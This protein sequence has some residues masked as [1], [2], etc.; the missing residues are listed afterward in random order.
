MPIKVIIIDDYPDITELLG[1]ILQSYGLQVA[2]ANDS[3][4]GLEMAHQ[5]IP[6]I[7]IL[8]LMMPG[9]SGWDVCHEV[10]AFSHVPIAILSA[11]DDP[12]MIASA[13]DAEADD[14]MVK[15]IPSSE[16]LAHINN[17]TR[18]ASAEK[19]DKNA[20][21]RQTGALYFEQKPV[22]A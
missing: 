6:D 7:I 3:A 20:L 13:L 1:L 9:K 14:Y 17:L 18:R 11:I 2:S 12:A 5:E 8:D 15:P 22:Q 21:L 16:L 10:R 4:I 19:G